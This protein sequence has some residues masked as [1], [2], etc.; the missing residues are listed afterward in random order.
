MQESIENEEI[1]L[2]KATVDAMFGC[3][4]KA[5]MLVGDTSTQVSCNAENRF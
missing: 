4:R 1:I 3:V 5:I 2:D